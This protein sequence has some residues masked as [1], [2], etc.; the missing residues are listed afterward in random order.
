[1]PCQRVRLWLTILSRHQKQHLGRSE[2]PHP[3]PDCDEGFLYPKDL[4]RHQRKHADQP[5]AQVTFFCP[6]PDCRSRGGFSRRD[7]LLRH[8]R[9]QHPR[10]LPDTQARTM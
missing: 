2:R 1:M 4:H 6:Y 7:N 3:C 9:K 8:Q 10:M 5:F